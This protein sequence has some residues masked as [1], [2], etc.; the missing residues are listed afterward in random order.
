VSEAQEERIEAQRLTVGQT[1]RTCP[2]CGYRDGFHVALERD[3]G[4]ADTNVVLKL[5]CPSCDAVYDVGL[6]A[7]LK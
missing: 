5:I 3:D 2:Q 4:P 6:A 7:F 1:L